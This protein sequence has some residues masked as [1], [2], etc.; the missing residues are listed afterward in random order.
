MMSE[1][2]FTSHNRVEWDTPSDKQL[3]EPSA[4]KKNCSRHNLCYVANMMSQSVKTF[5]DIELRV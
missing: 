3:F 5:F 4:F 1:L 2:S